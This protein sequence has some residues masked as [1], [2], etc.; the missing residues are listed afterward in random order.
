[1]THQCVKIGKGQN[2]TKK[3]ERENYRS[4]VL[5]ARI[6]DCENKMKGFIN[7]HLKFYIQG[8][9]VFD[10]LRKLIRLLPKQLDFKKLTSSINSKT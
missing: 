1:M 9:K 4:N 3:N 7:G 5:L 6:T 10:F 2:R 8:I